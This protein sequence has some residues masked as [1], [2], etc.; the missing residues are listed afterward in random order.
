VIKSHVEIAFNIMKIGFLGN[1]NNFPFLIA[2]AMKG[3]GHDVLFLINHPETLHRP[4]HRFHQFKNGY[5]DWIVDLSP[6][7]R[8]KVTDQGRREVLRLLNGCDLA[9][10]NGEGVGIGGHP[11][12]KIPHVAV[13]T[14]SDLTDL[15]RWQTVWAMNSQGAPGSLRLLKLIKGLFQ[16]W[17][18]VRRQRQGIRNAVAYSYFPKGLLKADEALLKSIRPKGKRVCFALA[19]TDNLPYVP[20]PNNMPLVLLNGAR[21]SWKKPNSGPY[22]ELDYKGTD[23]LVKGLALYL[24]KHS[25]AAIRLKLVKKGRDVNATQMLVNDLGIQDHVIWLEEMTQQE[26]LEAFKQADIVAENMAMSAPGMVTFDAMTLGRPVLVNAHPEFYGPAF[27][28]PF[29][30][31]QTRTPEDVC[32][33]LEKWV[34]NP[35]ER[36]KAGMEARNYAL[37]HFAPGHAAEM[38]LKAVFS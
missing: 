34:N 1:T 32:R 8:P 27:G 19:D 37:N 6:Y 33:W 35:K 31:G 15:A 30:V 2:Q 5:P 28:H 23:V 36:E 13:L 17:G 12:L 22:T 18:M 25:E 7:L 16:A 21:L 24:K 11:G 9:V 29:P 4:E 14:G 3:M 38:L 26:I 20:P 10:L